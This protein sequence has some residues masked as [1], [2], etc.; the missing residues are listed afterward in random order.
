MP[1]KDL[2]ILELNLYQK[3]IKTLFIIYADLECIIEM[4][5]GWKNIPENSSAT[6]VSEHVS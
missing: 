6:K 2:E 5:D 3:A 1:S 4:N